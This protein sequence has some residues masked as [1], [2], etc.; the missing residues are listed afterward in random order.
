MSNMVDNIEYKNRQNP[1]EITQVSFGEDG[2][3]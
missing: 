1:A 2:V 3:G